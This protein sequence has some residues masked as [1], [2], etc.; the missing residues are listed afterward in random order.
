MEKKDVKTLISPTAKFI[1]K[2]CQI[3]IFFGFVPWRG[4]RETGLSLLAAMLVSAL[5]YV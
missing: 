4:R 1:R 2:I 5:R 3:C